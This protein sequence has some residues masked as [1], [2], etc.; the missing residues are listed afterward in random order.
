MSK[1]AERRH[2]LRRMKAKAERLYGNWFEDDLE[3]T[4]K[5]ANHLC[6]CSKRCCGNE[7]HWAR[8]HKDQVTRQELKSEWKLREEN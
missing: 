8:N 2:H 7:R 1:R 5:W 3:R 4:H 6:L